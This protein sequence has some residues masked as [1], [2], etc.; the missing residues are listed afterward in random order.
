LLI[1]YGSLYPWHFVPV[2]LTANPLWI[3]LHAWSLPPGRYLLRDT[4]VN[5]VLYMPLGFAAHLVFRK[6]PLPGIGVYGPVLFG[7]MLSTAT[8]LLQLLEPSRTTSMADVAAN[9]IGSGIGVMA[10]L[11]FE[12]LVPR[13]DCRKPMP[14][15]AVADRGALLLVYCWG[16]WLFFSLFPVLGRYVLSR[17]LA[18]FEHS[19][20]VEPLLPA[21]AAAA[22]YAGG[23]LLAAAGVRISRA[24][25]ALTLLA[26]PAQFFAIERQPLPS[27][28]LGAVAGV[29]LFALRRRDDPPTKVE[30]GVFLAVIAVRGLSPFHSSAGSTEFNWVPFG[31][32]VEG[33]W[34]SAGSR[35]D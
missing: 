24:G 26:I 27:L 18:V 7:L 33:D 1:I 32:T 23:L 25:F 20:A 16:A 30:A 11:L 22:W 15:R 12:A 17:K 3:L 10:G 13:R 14:G 34:Q 2:H 29:L 28:L 31:A 8:K 21:S 9:V 4:I 5:V 19:G 35:A 6:N